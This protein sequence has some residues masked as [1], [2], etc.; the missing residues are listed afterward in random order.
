MGRGYLLKVALADL[1]LPGRI[2]NQ[3]FILRKHKHLNL[4]KLLIY[5]TQETY[6]GKQTLIYFFLEAGHTSWRGGLT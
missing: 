3:I 4:I 1:I 2:S 5:V 6:A